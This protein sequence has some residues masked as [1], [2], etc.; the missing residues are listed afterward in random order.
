MQKNW[1]G[2]SFGC[3]INFEISSSKNIKEIK[4]FTTR[5][6]TLFGLSFLALSVDHPLSKFY[7]NDEK[8]KN[9]NKNVQRM[10]LP[11]KLLQMQ[12][13]L[14]LKLILKQSIL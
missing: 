7:E 9:L 1:I 5:P 12:K 14:D 13:K 11:K 10:E 6:D 8:F 2:K 3:E 4:C